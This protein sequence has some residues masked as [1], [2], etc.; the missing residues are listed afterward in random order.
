[1]YEHTSTPEDVDVIGD[2]L[3]S[4]FKPLLKKRHDF[5]KPTPSSPHAS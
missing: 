1:M 3:S 2:R 5:L 4:T